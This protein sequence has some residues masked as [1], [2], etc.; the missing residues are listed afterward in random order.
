LGALLRERREDG[1]VEIL[2]TL[3]SALVVAGV[4]LILARLGNQRFEALEAS[5]V[6]VEDRLDGRID[7][8]DRKFGSKF[9]ALDSKVD[10]RFDAVDAKFDSKVDSLRADIT[11]I[12]LA[13]GARPARGAG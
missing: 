7:V 13:V 12:A 10:S 2:Q 1:Y 5:L 4:G 3:I 6:R 11:Q 9:E 8:L